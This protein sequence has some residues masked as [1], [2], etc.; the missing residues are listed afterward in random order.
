MRSH[1]KSHYSK[2]TSRFIKPQRSEEEQIVHD[3]KHKLKSIFQ[4]YTSFGDRF[5]SKHLKS[6]KFHKMMNDS[7]IKDNVLT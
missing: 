7:N 6:N 1:T 4:F 3:I 2:D 5:N